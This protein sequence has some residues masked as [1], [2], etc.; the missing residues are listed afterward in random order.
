MKKITIVEVE[1]VEYFCDICGRKIDKPQEFQLCTVCGRMACIDHRDSIYVGGKETANCCDIC[2]SM[3]NTFQ[4]KI[5]HYKD[6]YRKMSKAAI[7]NVISEWKLK[8]SE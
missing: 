6:F 7:K 5:K 4:K 3:S 8:S 1:N 2:I